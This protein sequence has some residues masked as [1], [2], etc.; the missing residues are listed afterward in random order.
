M[1]ADQRRVCAWC[2]RDLPPT[3][4]TGNA[5]HLTTHGLCAVC[6]SERIAEVS[7]PRSRKE[8]KST[9]RMEGFRAGGRSDDARR[10]R[11]SPG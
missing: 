2:G 8:R 11:R 1:E 6:L 5:A 4:P 9:E 10:F 3:A 7:A